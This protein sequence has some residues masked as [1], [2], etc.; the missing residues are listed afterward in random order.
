MCV[1]CG[2]KRGKGIWEDAPCSLWSQPSDHT[3]TNAHTRARAGATT[4]IT[5][6]ATTAAADGDDSC[7]M[8]RHIRSHKG[9]AHTLAERCRRALSLAYEAG[10]L[11]PYYA[12][13]APVAVAAPA[14]L[15]SLLQGNGDGGGS[16]GIHGP[17]LL[18]SIVGGGV[19]KRKTGLLRPPG[20][21]QPPPP[22]PSAEG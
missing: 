22:G 21:R 2:G 11:D 10:M 8:P 12:L 18:S 5:A 15:P 17:P 20:M 13:S 7:L 6:T 4:S 14:P 9:K 19:G 1:W 3:F 16:G